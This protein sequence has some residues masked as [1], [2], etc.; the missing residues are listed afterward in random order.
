MKKIFSTLTILVAAACMSISAQAPAPKALPLDPAVR[1]GVLEN[2]LTYYIRHNEEPKDRCEFHIAQ[3]VGATLEEDHQN[4]LAHFLEH[5]AFNGT[6]NFPDKM[7]INYFESIGVNFGGDINA[8]T[9]LDETVYRLSNVP[10]YRQ[11]ILDSALLV[12]HDWAAAISLNDAEIDNER[13]VIREEWRTVGNA[14]RRLW[15]KSSA[16]KFPGTPYAKRDVIGDTAVINNFT[17]QALRDYYHQWYGPDLQCI[18]VV[19]DIDVDKMEKDLV[20]LFSKIPARKN[21]GVRPV[22]PLGNNDEPIVSRITDPEGQQTRFGIQ[23]KLGEVDKQFKLSDQGYVYLL[24]QNLFYNMFS[25][26][27]EEIAQ[28]PKGAIMGGFAYYGAS[29]GAGVTEGMNFIGVSKAGKEEQTFRDLAIEI[30]RFRRYGFTPSEFERAKTET[31]SSYE[32][33]YN[34]RDTRNSQSLAQECYNH[35]LDGLPMPGIEFEYDYIKKFLPQINVALI[36]QAMQQ[37]IIEKNIILSVTG[38][39]KEGVNIPSKADMLR[40]F[41]EVKASK[42]EAPKEDKID[43]PLVE[44]TPAQAGT[45]VKEKFNKDLGTTEWTLS[46][47]AKV[48]IKTTDFKNDEINMTMTSRG[49]INKLPA[50]DL[51]SAELA[52]SIVS[53]NGIGTF[54]ALELQKV[55]TGKHA[56]ASPYIGGNYEGVSGRSTIKDFET[57]L[58]LAYLQFTGVRK[59]DDA[60]KNLISLVA[61]NLENKESNPKAIFGDSVSLTTSTLRERVVIMNKE[62]LGKVNQDKALEIFKQRFNN[63]GD[64]TTYFVGNIDPKDAKTRELICLWLGSQGSKAK[65]EKLTDTGNRNPKGVV[66]NYFA[67]DMEIKTATNRI[68]YYAPMKYNLKNSII[69]SMIGEILSTRYLESIREKEGGSYG[70]GTS[71]WV[72]DFPKGKATIYMGFDTDPEKQAKLMEIIHR[73]LETIVA[74]GPLQSD[75]DKTIEI[76]TKGHKE[77]LEKN[78]YWIGVIDS[79]YEDDMNKLE[80]LETLNSITPKDIQKALKK[81]V[82]NNNVVE[83]VMTPAK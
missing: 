45:I 20:A 54:T 24:I 68:Y 39:E 71:G 76:F 7:I 79:Y 70:V 49:G 31:L 41:N 47:G 69:M 56:S 81:I 34:E 13:G 27:F 1:M 9:S 63:M 37:M 67:R 75:F 58:Q 15:T 78:S 48:V 77:N 36:N 42:I 83:V 8:Y 38:P 52:T 12:M 33:A 44:N 30:E 23:F 3:A 25:Y 28:D 65:A 72:T 16:E 35:Y 73:E 6:K 17:Y 60:F 5:M 11:G 18:V 10:T 2:G 82:K 14:N 26:R 46:N 66:K 22:F 50:T 29:A 43:R 61:T 32:K 19:G 57:M 80:Y 53:F 74:N 40:I 4:G 64:F 51:P 21:R 62:T 55:L 59:D